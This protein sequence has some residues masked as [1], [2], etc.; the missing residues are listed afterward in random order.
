MVEKHVD[1]TVAEVL[2][3]AAGNFATAQEEQEARAAAE[4]RG[5]AGATVLTKLEKEVAKEVARGGRSRKS[6]K[7]ALPSSPSGATMPELDAEVGAV[8]RR[9]R[10][11]EESL[12]P[13]LAE[14]S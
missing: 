7:A 9:R 10:E 11:L 13:Y 12:A 3:A 5:A 6:R 1:E 8:I 14:V 4:V 2:R